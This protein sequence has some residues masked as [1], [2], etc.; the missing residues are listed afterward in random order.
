MENSQAVPMTP[1]PGETA[2]P[3]DD[4]AKV[5]NPFR[6]RPASMEDVGAMEQV[7]REAFPT[8]FPPTR[9]RQELGRSNAQ[10][11]VAA[12]ARTQEE[13]LKEGRHYGHGED[14]GD[15]NGLLSR[16]KDR[17]NRLVFDRTGTRSHDKPDEFVS[18]LV[19]LWFVL[20]EAHIVIIGARPSERRRGVGELLLIGGL[21]AAMRRGARVMTL[22]VRNSNQAARSLYRKYGFREVGLRKRY[23]ADNNEDAVIMTTPPIQNDEYWRHFHSLT[24]NHAERWGESVRV[25]S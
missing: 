17:A 18:G 7:E 23:Y 1:G 3:A 8:V 10:Y 16:I 2:S 19:G 21:E 5:R 22:E 12:R 4:A 11:L 25:L 6:L 14:D 20:D 13:M 24:R 9:F 15:P